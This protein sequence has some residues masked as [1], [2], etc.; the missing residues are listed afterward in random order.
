MPD[1]APHRHMQI[2]QTQ[3]QQRA[4]QEVDEQLLAQEDQAI[5]CQLRGAPWMVCLQQ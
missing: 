3:A 1:S 2:S 4:H 5:V